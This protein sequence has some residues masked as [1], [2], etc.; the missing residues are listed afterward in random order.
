MFI[1]LILLIEEI[2]VENVEILMCKVVERFYNFVFNENVDDMVDIDGYVVVKV[3]V[4]I[5]GI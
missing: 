3:V 2:V 5:D 4:V 1:Y